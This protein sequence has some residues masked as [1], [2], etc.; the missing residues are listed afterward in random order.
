MRDLTVGGQSVL[1]LGVLAH[2]RR[3]LLTTRWLTFE[4]LSR[5]SWGIT[6]NTGHVAVRVTVAMAIH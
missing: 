2:E 3:D 6:G 1:H 4:A 5:P